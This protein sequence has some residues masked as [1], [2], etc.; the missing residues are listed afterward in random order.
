MVHRIYNIR[1][2]YFPKYIIQKRTQYNDINFSYINKHLFINITV[3]ERL[4][5]IRI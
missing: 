2:K 4:H 3:I 1:A 5:I